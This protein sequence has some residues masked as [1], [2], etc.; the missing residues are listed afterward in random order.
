MEEWS[1]VV[2]GD[3]TTEYYAWEGF[4]ARRADVTY[5]YEYDWYDSASGSQYEED[6]W[7]RENLDSG[8]WYEGYEEYWRNGDTGDG[9]SNYSE[10][11]Y[12]NAHQRTYYEQDNELYTNW[13][14]TFDY[15]Y[16][17]SSLADSNQAS[18]Y[19]RTY[20]RD[21]TD[22]SQ[23]TY[24][25]YDYELNS[26]SG[27]EYYDYYYSDY[28][29]ANDTYYNY[30]YLENLSSGAY[31]EYES[32]EISSVSYVRSTSGMDLDYYWESNSEEIYGESSYYSSY[33]QVLASGTQSWEEDSRDY[34]S[35]DW[36]AVMLVN[37]ADDAWIGEKVQYTGSTG[38]YDLYLYQSYPDSFFLEEDLDDLPPFYFY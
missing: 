20:T 31:E 25:R 27:N 19:Y 7:Y 35:G 34:V 26:D 1:E 2:D 33:G 3:T 17:E 9:Y 16:E 38:Y 28:S 6:M 21:E 32:F 23:L 8:S 24:E 30:S 15:Y 18:V 13:Y 12:D 22:G 37:G 4:N 29:G 11:E 14:T 5:G 10:T 36:Y